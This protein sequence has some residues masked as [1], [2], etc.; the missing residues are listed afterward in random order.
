MTRTPVAYMERS[1]VYYEAQG[2]DQPYK[3]AHHLKTPFAQLKK[4]LK[5]LKATLVTTGMPDESYQG[6]NRRLAQLS[7]SKPPRS[8]FTGGLFWD[9]WATH[10]KDRE[11]YLPIKQLNQTVSQGLLGSLADYFYCVPNL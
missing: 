11:T 10:T 4:P 6:K 3:W 7:L 5:D 1:R 9:R 8:L 2:Y